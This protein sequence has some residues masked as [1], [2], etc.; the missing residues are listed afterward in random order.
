MRIEYLYY[1]LV[2]SETQ[3]LNKASNKLFISQQQLSR[4]VSS[5]E[6]ELNPETNLAAFSLKIANNTPIIT[7]GIIKIIHDQNPIFIMHI[8]FYAPIFLT[9]PLPKIDDRPI[10]HNFP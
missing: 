10:N 6:N 8:S 1:F 4:I 2:I 7:N 3:S 5:L 9:I